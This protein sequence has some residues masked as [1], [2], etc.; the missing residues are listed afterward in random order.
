[1]DARQLGGRG[2]EGLISKAPVLKNKTLSHRIFVP[3]CALLALSAGGVLTGSDGPQPLPL[4]P[5]IPAAKD[6]PYPGVIRLHVDARDIERHI[7]NVR[8]TIPVRGGEPLVL[9]YPQWLPANHAAYGRIENLAGLT[10][11]ANGSRVEWVRDPVNVFAFHVAVPAD[12]TTIEARFQFVSAVDAKQGRIVMTPEMLNLQWNSVTLYHAGHFVRQI[13]VQPTVR[14]PDGWQ[15]ATALKT[16]ASRGGTAFFEQVSVETLVDSPIFAGRYF[17]RLDLNPDGEVPV[18][19]NIVAD[20]EDYLEVKPEQLEAHRALVR[21]ADRLFGS[22]HYDRYEFLFALTDRMGGIG[23]EHHRSSENS[24]KPTYFTKWDETP[25][26]RDLLP[27]E[28]THSWNGKFRRPADLWT[29]DYT[30]P[31]RGSLLWLYEGQTQ[32]WGYVLAA[33]SGILSKQQT[34]D[35]LAYTAAIYDHRVGREWRALQDTTNDPVATMRRPLPWLSWER[36]EDYYSEGQLIWLDVDTLIREKSGGQK[37]LDDFARAFFGINDGS[38]V[39]VTYSF[40]DIATA[41]N[42]VQPHDWEAFLRTRLDEVGAPAPLDGIRRGGY[43]LVYTDTP[44][45]YFKHSESS[46]KEADLTYSVG[47]VIENEGRVKSVLWDGPAFKQG[48]TVGNRIIAVNGVAYDIDNLKHAI[49]NAAESDAAIDIL[50]R[51]GDRF[52]TVSLD[53]HDGLRYPHLKRDDDSP[54]HLDRILAP[55]D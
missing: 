24:A 25:R 10:I 13:M 3:V 12:A 27:H 30:A 32:Y 42:S 40:D 38:F 6:T 11:H 21:Q 51:D 49:K 23:L 36:S 43:E 54:G 20:R 28:Y 16:E 55:R 50:V 2:T 19:L 22:H 7:F 17:K 26:G 34:L 15:L 39:P 52:R 18:H 31:M 47:M 35:V 14:V 53:Y 45:E 48:L 44:S 33:R 37:S 29:P 4:P 9:L 5:P 41:L 8:E 1:M 46:R